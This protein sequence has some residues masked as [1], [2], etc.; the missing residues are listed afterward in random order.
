MAVTDESNGTGMIMPVQP[1]GAN[2]GY[3][4]GFGYGV[5]YAVPFANG[6]GGGFGNGFGFGGDG[7]ILWLFIIAMMFGGFG[8][9]WGMGGF[10]GMWGMEGM[11]PWLLASNANNQN[12]TQ[13]GFNQA[14]TANT[15]S[16]IQG[17]ITSGFGD[18][19]LGIA[20]VNQNICQTGASITNAVNQGFAGVNQNISNGFAGVQTSLCNGFNGVNQTVSN[21]FAQ[22]EIS[23]NNRQ[24]ANM[25]QNY[26]N[27]LANV[28]AMNGIQ[29]G[30][31]D[32]CCRT[33]SGIDN[34]R[35]TVATE[36]CADRAAVGDALQN[37]TMQN[38]NSTNAIVSTIRDGIQSIKDDLCADRLDAERRENQNL[39]TQLNMANLAASQTAQTSRL[40]ADNAAQTQNI[41][42]YIRP[43]I[44]PAYIVPNPYACYYNGYGNNTGCCNG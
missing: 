19:Q 31:T 32:C 27:Q 35:Y 4:G 39:R 40:L 2:Y 44:N 14:A 1:M 26:T 20:G 36:A 43:Q 5:P 34:L 9:G 7:S 30:I 37:V 41:E 21:G 28:Q 6:F 22:A 16:G 10:G 13:G 29:N 3:N 25:Q 17:A 18:T 24:M 42:N 12:A 8:G 33:Q 23:A 15:L 11:F 38:L